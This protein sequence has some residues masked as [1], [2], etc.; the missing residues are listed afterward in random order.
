M[1]S[2]CPRPRVLQDGHQGCSEGTWKKRKEMKPMA[3]M[4]KALEGTGKTVQGG[5]HALAAARLGWGVMVGL[6][7]T[8]FALSVPARYGEL[9]GLARQ[10]VAQLGHG[11]GLDL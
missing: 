10:S 7:L 6:S 2:F 5:R 9:A 8:L 11:S 4:T 1:S 3:T